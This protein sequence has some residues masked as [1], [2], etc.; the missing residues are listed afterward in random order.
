MF[1]TSRGA[2]Q[3]HRVTTIRGPSSPPKSIALAEVV[4]EPVG[5]TGRRKERIEDTES[6]PMGGEGRGNRPSR[7]GRPAFQVTTMDSRVG[8]AFRLPSW[9]VLARG[10]DEP[11]KHASR[12]PWVLSL[13]QIHLH[14]NRKILT[15]NCNQ[16]ACSYS[17]RSSCRYPLAEVLPHSLEPP[18]VGLVG[19]SSANAQLVTIQ[20]QQQDTQIPETST[21]ERVPVR[22]EPVPRTRATRVLLVVPARPARAEVRR[23]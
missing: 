19:I 14:H 20:I 16:L 12:H 10:R 13:H 1:R 2:A 21:E 8:T 22:S 9:S 23:S 5:D 15:S 11:T 4:V 18:V 6:R 7:G 3:T 17:G